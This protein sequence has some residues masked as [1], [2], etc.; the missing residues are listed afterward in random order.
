[1]AF[2]LKALMSIN[3]VKSSLRANFVSVAIH[4]IKAILKFMSLQANF[5]YAFLLAITSKIAVFALLQR[6]T[7]VALVPR[8]Q[9][10]N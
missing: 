9:G 2:L 7:K 1:M 6:Q 4:R 10:V 5:A 8:T 3:L